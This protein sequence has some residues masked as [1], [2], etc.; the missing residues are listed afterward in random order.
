MEKK[1]K[2]PEDAIL[3]GDEISNEEEKKKK[4]TES[5]ISEE[6]QVLKDGL[7]A[8]VLRLQE[9]SDTSVHEQALDYLCS[10]IKTST[11]DFRAKTFKVFKTIL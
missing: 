7:E 5:E 2:V 3:N 4:K 1:A 10:E 9:N 11:S 8:A 6:D